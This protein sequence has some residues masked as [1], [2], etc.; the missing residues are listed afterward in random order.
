MVRRRNQLMAGTVVLGEAGVLSVRALGCLGVMQTITPRQ[1]ESA[2]VGDNP[3]QLTFVTMFNLFFENGEGDW[4]CVR[5]LTRESGTTP[6]RAHDEPD[7]IGY[8]LWFIELNVVPALPC[9][10][11]LAVM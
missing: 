10:D 11:Q 8:N 7:C 3:V 5:G 4:I 9:D 1:R 2:K 6:R